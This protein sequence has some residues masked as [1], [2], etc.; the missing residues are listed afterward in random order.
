MNADMEKIW[1]KTFAKRT[2]KI[3]SSVIRELLNYPAAR[4]NFIC[5]WSSC[6]GIIPYQ[7]N[8]RSM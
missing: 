1:G 3:K 4:Y 7:R 8:R 5:W 2:E 6:T